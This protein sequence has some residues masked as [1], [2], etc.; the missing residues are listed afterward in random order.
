MLFAFLFS[1]SARKSRSTLVFV[2]IVFSENALA[3]SGRSKQIN[4]VY[5][6]TDLKIY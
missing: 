2:F 1:L 5:N 3:L 4:Q 6:E